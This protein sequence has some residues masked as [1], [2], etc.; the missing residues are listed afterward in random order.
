[1]K[2]KILTILILLVPLWS[3]SQGTYSYSFDVYGMDGVDRGYGIS[4]MNDGIILTGGSLCYNFSRS[5]IS[6]IKTDFEGNRLWTVGLDDYPN[7]IKLVAKSSVIQKGDHYVFAGT[8]FYQNSN[9]FRMALMEFDSTGQ[10]FWKKIYEDSSNTYCTSL[11]KLDHGYLLYG[12]RSNSYGGHNIHFIKTDMEGNKVWSHTLP[13]FEYTEIISGGTLSN[14]PGPLE[15]LDNG[16]YLLVFTTSLINYGGKGKVFQILNENFEP[17][18]TKEFLHT[19]M[20]Q[21]VVG[22]A[23]E[24]VNMGRA[25]DG[26]YAMIAVTDTITPSNDP[27]IGIEAHMIIGLDTLGEVQWTSTFPSG[28]ITPVLS[29]Q[30]TQNGDIIVCGRTNNFY[31]LDENGEDQR[32]D[33]AWMARITSTGEQVWRREY[34]VR[35]NVAIDSPFELQDLVELPDGRIAAI[36]QLWEKFPNGGN[37]GNIWLL[38]VDENGC[39]TPDCNESQIWVAVEEPEDGGVQVLKQVYF[40]VSPNPASTKVGIHFYEALRKDAYM[41]VYSPF[42]QLMYKKKLEKGTKNNEIGVE[43]LPEGIYVVILQ[44]EGRI[45]QQEKVVVIK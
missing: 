12:T 26:G 13:L 19:D 27:I 33:A 3:F 42:G 6:V 35:E 31:H 20:D 16:N 11:K 17:V 43:T 22:G 37:N 2:N 30:V 21:S 36:G 7:T 18:V 45:L 38:I 1:M 10:I 44:Q 39:Y 28:G 5:C 24:D 32:E 29:F 23:F 25:M 14:V 15:I 41:A 4:V 40:K 34:V 9:Q 8:V